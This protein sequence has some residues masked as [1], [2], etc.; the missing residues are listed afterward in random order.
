MPSR[1]VSRN[2]IAAALRSGSNNGN[3]SVMGNVQ[4][5]I[6]PPPTGPDFGEL[7]PLM[8]SWARC[9]K[10]AAG[11]PMANKLLICRMHATTSKVLAFDMFKNFGL[12]PSNAFFF[13]KNY[14]YAH[15]D[16]VID[17]MKARGATVL[18]DNQMTPEMFEALADLADARD[19]EVNTIED[20]AHALELVLSNPRL[21]A[22]FTGGTE[23]TSRGTWIGERL[24]LEGK[25]PKPLIALSTST[26][27][28]D[29]EGP[30]VAAAGLQAVQ[31][32]FPHQCVSDWHV[33]ILGGG[34]IGKYTLAAFDSIGCKVRVFDDDP[35][36]RIKLSHFGADKVRRSA[37]DAVRGANLIIGTAGRPTIDADVLSVT[38]KTVIVSSKSSEQIEINLTYIKR[39]AKRE[40][41]MLLHPDGFRNNAVIGTTYELHGNKLVH[42]LFDGMPLN[43]SRFGLLCEKTVDVVVGWLALCALEIARGAYRTQTGILT[44]A[45]DEVFKMHQIA[46]D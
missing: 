28:S 9:P 30:R 37:L 22:R 21:A 23:Q 3:D 40:R 16:D 11:A 45:A 39:H 10:L 6:D 31:N 12:E 1:T 2:A 18:P 33:G 13:Y 46:E 29:F 15:F 27:K 38:P 36:A 4:P 34:V 32:L 17:A 7:F 19:L 25:L 24:M 20:G 5:A 43:F 44:K 35:T 8:S 26:I 42:V 41:P 14:P